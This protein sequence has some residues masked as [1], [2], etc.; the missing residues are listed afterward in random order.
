MFEELIQSLAKF[1]SVVVE[2]SHV[3]VPRDTFDVEA[4]GPGE[5]VEPIVLSEGALSA[6][7]MGESWWR[8][9]GQATA[10]A[11]W[12]VV[13][14]LVVTSSPSANFTPRISFGNWLPPS[15]RRQ[16]RCAASTSLKTMASAVLLERQP[17]ER[18]ARWR[19]VA[20]FSNA[21][22][23]QP[24]S[25]RTPAMHRGLWRGIGR[26]WRISIRSS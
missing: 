3:T 16:A 26:P 12:R 25:R 8:P 10:V 15:R 6:R 2:R 24:G 23:A 5:S 22:S 21:S 4:D 14:G 1:R 7:A 19:T 13:V 20:W 17:F 11:G 18:M 9:E